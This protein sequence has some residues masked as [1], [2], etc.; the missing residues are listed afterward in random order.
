MNFKIQRV[1]AENDN[2][3]LEGILKDRDNSVNQLSCLNGALKQDRDKLSASKNKL[4]NDLDR[5]KNHIMILTE[6]TIKII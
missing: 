2:V 1:Q 3:R 4:M 5:Y 6:Q